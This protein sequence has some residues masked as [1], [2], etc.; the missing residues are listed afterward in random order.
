MDNARAFQC[1][2]GMEYSDLPRLFRPAGRPAKFAISARDTFYRQI[3]FR[4]IRGMAEQLLRRVR[5]LLDGSEGGLTG[6]RPQAK[7]SAANSSYLGS[8][9]MAC[10][11][12]LFFLRRR[13]AW[14]R[15]EATV[16]R[17]IHGPDISCALAGSRRE[18]GLVGPVRFPFARRH[19]AWDPAVAISW[20]LLVLQGS[21]DL[22]RHSRVSS[23]PPWLVALAVVVYFWFQVSA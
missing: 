6:A 16:F 14:L 20:G 3:R 17:A 12:A 11:T 13:P 15:P 8:T 9:G 4:A 5:A 2:V 22:D 1:A 7:R 18:H 10:A 21:R 23:R 19:S